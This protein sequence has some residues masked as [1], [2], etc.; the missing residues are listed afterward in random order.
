METHALRWRR[1]SHDAIQACMRTGRVTQASTPSRP[2]PHSA[3]HRNASRN[4][5]RTSA[6]SAPTGLTSAAVGTMPKAPWKMAVEAAEPRLTCNLRRWP[7]VE[8][9]PSAEG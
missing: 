5:R 8:S 1:A 6:T 3:L 2:V 7:S 4:A 9:W